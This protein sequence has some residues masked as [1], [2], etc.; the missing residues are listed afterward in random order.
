MTDLKWFA[1]G[2]NDDYGYRYGANNTFVEQNFKNVAIT[3]NED[4]DKSTFVIWDRVWKDSEDLDI[5]RINAILRAV[6]FIKN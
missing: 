6:E 3:D 1:I 4:L 2:L 5:K